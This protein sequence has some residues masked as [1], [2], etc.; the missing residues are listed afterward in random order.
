MFLWP[1]LTGWFCWTRSR[2]AGKCKSRVQSYS[3]QMCGSGLVM[4]EGLRGPLPNTITRALCSVTV[5]VS[6]CIDCCNPID[7]S[8][9]GSSVHGILQTRIVEWIAMPF[10]KGS[11]Q[12]R[13]QDRVSCISYIAGRFF[14][15]EPPGK[16]NTIIE[17]F[18]NLGLWQIIPGQRYRKHM[19]S[20]SQRG[21]KFD[22][23]HMS[24]L[25]HIPSIRGVTGTWLTG[26]WLKARGRRSS[27]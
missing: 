13:G 19:A 16:P 25:L 10:S 23:G 3:P 8:P 15:A 22:L 17:S 4:Y 21:F 7:C 18:L 9:P 6:D 2:E 24:S 14:T 5:V 1:L 27:S 11:S 20:E 26:L 12:P